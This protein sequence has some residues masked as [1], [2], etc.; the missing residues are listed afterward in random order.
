MS[1]TDTTASGRF[2]PESTRDFSQRARHLSRWLDLP[3]QRSQELLA[4]IYGYANLHELQ[5][6]LDRAE[7]PGPFEGNPTRNHEPRIARLIGEFRGVS[8]HQISARDRA[9]AS[10]GLFCRADQHRL[11]FK[12][13]RKSGI[14]SRASVSRR[15][16][17]APA[18]THPALSATFADVECAEDEDIEW[19][20]TEAS[21]GRYVS[22]YRLIPRADAQN[23][24]NES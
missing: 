14:A 15:V 17:I 6:E 19:F 12:A 11:M 9:V 2:R 8:E 1:S 7:A 18:P 22:G 24:E 21:V 20:W 10:M 16:V 3:Y 4:R 5:R 23:G 13:L